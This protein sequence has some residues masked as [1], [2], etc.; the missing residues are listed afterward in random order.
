[1]GTVQFVSAVHE[2]AAQLKGHFAYVTSTPTNMSI[3]IVVV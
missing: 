1:M 3:E 2:A